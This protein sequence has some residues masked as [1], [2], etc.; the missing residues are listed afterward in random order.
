MQVL[1]YGLSPTQIEKLN[2]TMQKWEN[3]NLDCHRFGDIFHVV[4]FFYSR[5]SQPVHKA[6][7]VTVAHHLLA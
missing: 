6:Y 3:Y 2:L 4:F 7:T 1:L 5:Y